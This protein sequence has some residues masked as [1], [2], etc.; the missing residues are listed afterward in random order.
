MQDLE[1]EKDEQTTTKDKELEE[2]N[3]AMEHLQDKYSI[4]EDQ[5]R[6]SQNEFE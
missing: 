2:R 6:Q 4:L 5:F 3:M 1:Q